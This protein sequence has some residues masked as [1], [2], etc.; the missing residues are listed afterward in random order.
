VNVYE[1]IVIFDANLSDEA[2]E[3]ATARVRDTITA[4]GGESLKIEQWG[5]RKLAYEINKHA[6]GHYT[7]FI[8]RAPSTVNKTVE[9]LCK[10][11][12]PVIKYMIVKF[13]KKQREH[14]LKG[15]AAAQAAQAAAAAAPAAETPEAPATEMAAAE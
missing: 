14:V 11:Y 4:G 6:R 15:I 3:E 12:D 1:T 8:Y 9:D 2:T 13:E 5:K 10:V 7:L